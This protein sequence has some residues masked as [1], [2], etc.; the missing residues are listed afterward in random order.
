MTRDERVGL[1]ILVVFLLTSTVLCTLTT[2]GGRA[3]GNIFANIVSY[4]DEVRSPA[5]EAQFDPIKEQIGA[6]WL[7]ALVILLGGL[8]TLIVIVGYMLVRRRI[9]RSWCVLLLL[10]G[11]LAIALGFSAPSIQ[12]SIQA[13]L[14]PPG[15]FASSTRDGLLIATNML[16]G[17]AQP[18]A[19]YLASGLALLVWSLLRRRIAQPN[20]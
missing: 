2:G 20:D 18:G 7:P 6:Y 9:P 17:A 16:T 12:A 14:V 3:I 10:I 19:L 5:L 15:R 1:I 11:I 8:V 13:V 4:T